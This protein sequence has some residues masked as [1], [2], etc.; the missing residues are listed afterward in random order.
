MATPGPIKSLSRN[1]LLRAVVCWLG[2]QYIRL[3]WMSGRWTRIR[4]EIPEKYWRSGEP[5]IACFWHGRLLMMGYNWDRQRDFY[6]LISQH[7]DGQL[8]AR[9]VEKFGF[10]TLAGSSKR[11]G[12]EALRAMLRVIKDGG[13]VGITPDGPRGPRMRASMGAIALA[14]LS[15]VPVIPTVFACRRRRVLNSWD[16]F[17][18]PG[19]FSKGVFVWGEAF[20]VPRDSDDDMMEGFRARLETALN[21]L[22]READDLC[23][24]PAIDPAPV[25]PPLSVKEA[26]L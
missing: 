20:D 22:T 18:L 16:R 12:G 17:L 5:F 23:G 26:A 3:V 15:G 14:K 11:G 1:T 7:A 19:L 4:A 24:S 6:M 9:T 10:K 25:E 8:I 21:D 2:A 13:S